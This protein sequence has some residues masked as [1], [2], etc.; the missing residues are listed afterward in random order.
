MGRR[1]ESER[2]KRASALS[3]GKVVIDPLEL[4]AKFWLDPFSTFSFF[5]PFGRGFPWKALSVESNLLLKTR[6]GLSP[7]SCLSRHRGVL[8]VLFRL[9][10][11]SKQRLDD[12]RR[13]TKDAVADSNDVGGS[14]DGENSSTPPQEPRRGLCRLRRDAS[15]LF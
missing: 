3:E 4:E 14:G 12:T 7:L 15:P 8:L 10:L 6:D 5:F 13:S 11:A 2:E 1:G 9:L